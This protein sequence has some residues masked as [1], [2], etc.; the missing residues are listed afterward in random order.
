MYRLKKLFSVLLCAVMVM[1]VLPV[2]PAFAATQ[3]G[4]CGTNLKWVLDEKTG[5]LTISGTGAMTNYGSYGAPWF[6]YRD[7][8]TSIV[9]ENGVTSI[10]IYA[11][12]YYYTR[13]DDKEY[14]SYYYRNVKSVTIPD[15]LT[16]IG[17][18]AFT[19]CSALESIELPERLTS[20]GSYA[21]SGCTSLKSVT[22]HDR[23]QSIGEYAFEN[24]SALENIHLSDKLTAI[25]DY[26]FYG[27]LSLKKAD[28]PN[29]VTNI[30][31]YA[32]YNC[33]A[34]ESIV[35]PDG[36]TNIG[37][38]AFNGCSTIESL[39]IPENV[40]SIGANAFCRCGN[41]EE[42][43]YNAVNAT[44][45]T[46]TYY[47]DYTPF[48]NASIVNVVIGNNVET[49][50]YGLFAD[51]SGI[52][53]LTIGSG[54][55]TIGEKAFDGCNGIEDI[56]YVGDEAAWEEISVEDYNSGL[57]LA[58]M[59]YVSNHTVHYDA[60]GG[61]N[62]PADQIKSYGADLTL[63]S[64]VPKRI[65][66]S[67]AGWATSKTAKYAEYAPGASYTNEED[68]TLYAVWNSLANITVGNTSARAGSTVTIP[69]SIAN[70]PGMA[71]FNFQINY[72][73]TKLTP[74]SIVQGK[75]LTAGMLT[76]NLQ[77]GGDLSRFDYIT[78]YWN[79]PSN[80]NG[81]GEIL[82]ITF[83][84]DENL[85][86]CVIPITLSYH[87]GDVTNQNFED[88]ALN[89]TDGTITVQNVVIGDV[90]ADGEVNSKDG[91]K[92]SQYLAKWDV[93]LTQYE[94][95]AADVFKDGEINSKDGLRLSQYLAKWDVTL[96]SAAE[97]EI[98]N[99]MAADNQVSFK[100]GSA[101]PK[102]GDYVDIPV[103][104]TRNSGMATFNVELNYDSSLLTPISISKGAALADGT[105]TSNLQQSNFNA[106]F[107]TAY[108]VSPANVN[109]TGHAFTVRF[110]VNQGASGEIPVE[111]SYDEKDSPLN[112]N[113]ESLSVN[114]I[115]GKIT[116]N[117]A[118]AEHDYSVNYLNTDIN[119]SSI[120]VKASVTKNS[121]R[122]GEDA[123]VIA[124]YKNGQLIDKIF[125]TAEFAE[126]QT[127]TFGGMMT[128]VE[129]ATIKAFVWDS[130]EDM[131][132][133]SNS[134]ERR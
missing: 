132:S 60:N 58:R 37:D 94:T 59:H 39:V 108:W 14:Y 88:I 101:Q 28:I 71:T 25:S 99:L 13:G 126:G 128:A 130:L 4:T 89:I 80:I 87:S 82:N 96:E 114:I 33:A 81:N 107:V 97:E 48:Q 67:F 18:Y 55:K 41:L 109:N 61:T 49:I 129:G 92:L 9:I 12:S 63:S 7:K 54:V 68:I 17:D 127:V 98:V 119:G 1:G 3:S 110:K 6:D 20:L 44:T 131:Q 51:C 21:F 29:R 111:L 31:K 11:F 120:T 15:K 125:M 133:L 91:L 52:T 36:A 134:L 72:D 43:Y 117:G 50:P 102:A 79:N 19:N 112:Q 124:M 2:L 103:T 27:C 26:M 118:E 78:A 32:F 45:M 57:P 53:G 115:N 73:K 22:A 105:L 85:E 104:I 93:T 90:F 8:I 84:L 5:V 35:I 122:S 46:S 116:V 106:N 38:D 24:C 123:I 40:E 69:V 70:N 95:A 56:Y 100:V 75:A 65:N 23:I 76:S 74:V 86:E 66:Y 34:L 42:V 83:K 10:G 30:G 64:D 113:F 77:Q 62:A 16:S 47:A 121:A